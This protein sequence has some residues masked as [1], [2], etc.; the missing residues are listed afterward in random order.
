VIRDGGQ[1]MIGS[2][3][4]IS[5]AA[6][7]HDGKATLAMLQRHSGENF[8]DLLRRLDSAIAVS[9]SSGKCVDEINKPESEYHYKI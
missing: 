4:P 8:A 3:A 2:V 6:V 7:A 1:I 5:N 9:R